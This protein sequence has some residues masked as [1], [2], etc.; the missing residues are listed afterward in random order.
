MARRTFPGKHSRSKKEEGRSEGG[1]ILAAML[2]PGL[3]TDSSNHTF[4]PSWRNRSASGRTTAW[5]FARWLRKTSYWKSAG[6]VAGQ[7]GF[8]AMPAAHGFLHRLP[9]R[10]QPEVDVQEVAHGSSLRMARIR[11]GV[12]GGA[13]GGAT[14]TGRPNL[15]RTSRARIGCSRWRTSFSPSSENETFTPA[16]RCRAFRKRWGITN[17]P[18]VESVALFTVEFLPGLPKRSSSGKCGG[19]NGV[20]SKP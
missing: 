13:P 7:S 20:E 8:S 14:R 17:W 16:W 2:S 6:I 12:M 9:R 19:G 1:R 5:S 15:P 3:S 4:S 11:S 10:G 18:F